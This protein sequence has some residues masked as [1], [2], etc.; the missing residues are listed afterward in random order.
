MNCHACNAMYSCTERP[1]VLECLN[2]GHKYKVV[3]DNLIDYHKS[4]YRKD[5]RNRR[6]KGEFTPDGRPTALFHK[7]REKIVQKRLSACM[8][9]LDP[10]DRGLDIGAGAGTWAD[11][12]WPHMLSIDCLEIDPKLAE[13]CK[14]HDRK[15]FTKDFMSQELDRY[16]TTFLWHVLEHIENIRSLVNKIHNVTKKLFVCE[17]PFGRPIPERFDGHVHYFTR[18][19]FE[20]T[21]SKFKIVEMKPGIQSPALLAILNP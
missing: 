6:V 4:E 16:D 14:R 21:L 10:N 12:V 20:L 3:R 11:A 19:S 18:K 9:Y 2:C 15:V 5:P 8:K 13:A 17:I 7:A 1:N